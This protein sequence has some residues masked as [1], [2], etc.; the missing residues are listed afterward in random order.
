MSAKKTFDQNI[1][2]TLLLIGFICVIFLFTSFQVNRLATNACFD[3]LDDATAQVAETICTRVETDREQLEVIADLLAQHDL[4]DSD[5]IKGHLSSY[6]QRG[7]LSAVGLLLPDSRLILGVGGGETIR[8]AFDYGAELAKLP[9]TS[10]IVTIPDGSG[11][12]AFCQAVPV[13]KDGQIAAILYGFVSLADF[14]DS[15]TVTAFDGNAQIYV[16]DGETGDF[17]VDTWHDELGNIFDEGIL[18]RKVK[19]GYGFQE[20]K[21]DFVEGKAGHIAFLSKTAGEYFYSHY[22]PV[23]V[24]RW[25]VQMTVPESVVFANALQIRRVLYGIAVLEIISFAACFLWVFSRVRRDAAQK[26]QRLAQS[27]YMYDVQQTLFDAHKDPALFTAALQKVAEMLT[28]ERAFFLTLERGDVK[29]IMFSSAPEGETERTIDKEML[30]RCFPGIFQLL[31]SG[32]SLLFRSEELRTMAEEEREEL[33]RRRI[34]NL[35]LVPVLDS[36]ETLV[37]I[38][39]GANMKRRWA[40]ST[41]LECVS[42]NFLMA[43]SNM[44][45]YRQIE[46]M[47]MMDA[48]TGLR[49][50]NCYESSLARYEESATPSLCC[51]YID[52]NGLHELNNTLGHSAGDAMLICVGDALRT[53]FPLQDCYRIGG[54]EFVAFGT[55]CSREEM[56]RRVAGLKE[57]VDSFGYHISVGEARLSESHDVKD[58]VTAA[59]RNMYEAK[60]L[61]YQQAG[62]ISKARLLNQKL[63]HI[64]LEKR[65]SDAFLAIIATRFMGVYVVDMKN[66]LARAIYK[67]SYFADILE[68]NRYHFIPSMEAYCRAYVADG[69]EDFLKELSYDR[70]CR[71]LESRRV[72][73]Y[74]YQQKD[75]TRLSL[76][77][78]PARDYSPDHPEAIWLF[79]EDSD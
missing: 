72:V 55:D 45:F 71:Q 31:A 43:L 46:R 25:M 29:N 74:G 64:L 7:T 20:M 54:D 1:I 33:S 48:L 42:R 2:A 57:R 22:M 40:D 18:N 17:L 6:R 76:L 56:E 4:Q 66:D 15:I 35:M 79:E 47:S 14:A 41:L 23:G 70:I 9:Y 52:A 10:G 68:E 51:L 37:G 16:A 5:M 36:G 69:G 11:E 24:N 39:G 53:F 67:P 49:N 12:K 60:R 77:I 21:Q 19:P 73:R 63:E 59:E 28:A 75:G 26:N 62:S 61:Y 50:R 38:L 34:D 8:G 3:T 78:Y 27:L 65:D 30:R 13:E 32:Q 44:T 58:M